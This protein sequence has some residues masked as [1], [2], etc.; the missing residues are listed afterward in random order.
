VSRLSFFFTTLIAAVPAAFLGYLC[1]Y[2]FLFHSEALP[3]LL[4]AVA[5]ITLLLCAVI[6]ALPVTVLLKGRDHVK[7]AEDK[8]DEA[9]AKEAT[10]TEAAEDAAAEEGASEDAV[11]ATADEDVFIEGETEEFDE[12]DETPRKR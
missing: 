5:G 12:F 7:A 2:A 1:V 9:A 4:M 11:V 8:K 3:V 10:S 6:I